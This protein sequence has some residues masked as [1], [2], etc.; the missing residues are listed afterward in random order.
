MIPESLAA[1]STTVP[2][3]RTTVQPLRLDLLGGF[4]LLRDQQT[5]TAALHRKTQALL[6]WLAGNTQERTHTREQ[7]AS[8]LWPDMPAEKSRN[9]LRQVLYQLR[10]A[11]GPAAQVVLQSQRDNVRLVAAEGL[12]VDIW[13]LRAPP[14]ACAVCAPSA[15][16]NPCTHQLS[17]LHEQLALYRGPFLDGF[18]LP[19]APDFEQWRDQE[20]DALATQALSLCETLRSA[21][22]RAGDNAR[23]LE[24]ARKSVDLQP[25][26]EALHCRYMTALIDAGQS[27]QALTW[28]R[29]LEHTLL[30][31]FGVMPQASTQA[32]LEQLHPTVAIRLG[33][34]SL[35]Q[36]TLQAPSR[37]L[38]S[39][40]CVHIA[41]R[42]GLTAADPDAIAETKI[43]V[44]QCL[45]QHGGQVRLVYGDYLM[46][47]FG[48][49]LASQDAGERAASAALRLQA[50]LAAH[51]DFRA[52]LS[53]ATITPSTDPDLVD[54]DGT[55]SR[56]AMT[57]CHRAQ[58][59][60]I[61]TDA[62]SE[63]LLNDRFQLAALPVDDATTQTLPAHLLQ[64]ALAAD[65]RQCPPA[66]CSPIVGRANELARLRRSWALARDGAPQQLLL[67][68]EVGMGKSCLAQAMC[69]QAQEEGARIR[70]LCCQIEQRDTPLFPF[71]TLF[72][73]LCGFAEDDTAAQRYTK[74]V[75]Y[76]R[77]HY[78]QI[79][80]EALAV[81][82]T[83]LIDAH[84][85][86]SGPAPLLPRQQVL[87][88]V[89]LIIENLHAQTATPLL[90]LVEELQWADGMTLGVLET[91]AHKVSPTPF[92]LLLTARPGGVPAWLDPRHVM[93]LRALPPTA[94]KAMVTNMAPE[95][96][97]HTVQSIATRAGGVPLF[98]RELALASSR[99][100]PLGHALPPTLQYLLRARLD[101]V[102]QGLRCLQLAASIG[103]VIDH[104]LLARVCDLDDDAF[105]TQLAA[106][107]RAQLLEPHP[108]QPGHARFQH[109]L[110]RQVA[111]D[112]Q[113]DSDRQDAH[114]RI[115]RT[116][117][118]QFP[119]RAA[120]HPVILAQHFEA[121]GSLLSAVNWWR[122]AGCQALLVSACDQAVAHLEKGVALVEKLQA[123]PARDA[124]A[125]SLLIPLGQ[126][127]LTWHGYGS[128]E[129]M[130]VHERA[131]AL[132][133]GSTPPLQHFEVR[134]GHWIV[135]SSQPGSN[136]A[137]SEALARELLRLAEDANE[138]T[139]LAHA[140]SALA[141][142]ALWRNRVEAA[143]VHAHNSLA[144]PVGALDPE[145]SIDAIH[146]HVSSLAHAAWAWHRL[147]KTNKAVDARRQC[148][149]LAQSLPGPQSACMAATF[150]AVLAVMQDEPT[151]VQTL[152]AELGLLARRHDMALWLGG[153]TLLE[154]W[155]AAQQGQAHGAR[156]MQQA[157]DTL[158]DSMPSV[159]CLGFYLLARVW[160]QLG[161]PQ[162]RDKAIRDGISAA[163]AVGEGFFHGLLLEMG[164][165]SPA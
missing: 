76:L 132:C 98:A 27:T 122:K 58:A 90:L 144:H 110:I 158:Q 85:P 33:H 165:S 1:S 100:W 78:P 63:A 11:L 47:H 40:L 17:A 36:I 8:L 114:L 66:R 134:L 126:A 147:G 117:S 131:L 84:Y 119:V 83:I 148:L 150:G 50:S 16:G 13:Q 99:G 97:P 72:E 75:N 80:A 67:L 18:T 21:A 95:L 26:N 104:A 37:R 52:G 118:T 46:A 113:L 32:V 93:A 96:D 164:A 55:A 142:T 41:V 6:A 20:R 112:S 156:R 139:L 31:E 138:P 129:A 154:G 29:Q 61:L 161:R 19:D 133:N 51:F 106:L 30:R 57:L 24:Y 107:T 48:V 123:N 115:A 163:A 124:L 94:I 35:P 62:T 43:S 120:Q 79:M 22:A 77:R 146:P 14:A 7:L 68:G 64:A 12:T 81:L 88:I 38:A 143:I 5:L 4:D 87:S 89:P 25:W 105:T 101:A 137:Q 92:L 44:A 56:R 160:E 141:N 116:L 65:P 102:P 145:R 128:R 45:R 2:G 121:A 91:L 73:S 111:Y 82:Q 3:H 60:Q 34:P 149:T 86:E 157:I 53:T 151:V 70:R 155:L 71:I 74:L 23:A 42:A 109:P 153:H 54:L 28:Y 125:L 127:L 103:P 136:F 59:G 159:R 9:N 108:A 135:S 49:P 39:V 15:E 140:H 162:A 69:Q 152:T 10:R 130:R